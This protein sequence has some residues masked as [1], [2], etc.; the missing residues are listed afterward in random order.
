MCHNPLLRDLYRAVIN[1]YPQFLKDSFLSFLDTEHVD[2]YLHKELVTCIREQNA[3]EA[4]NLTAK[5]IE[6]EA[7]DLHI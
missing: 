4:R 5:M 2:I 1:Y 7:A 3:Q 6:S